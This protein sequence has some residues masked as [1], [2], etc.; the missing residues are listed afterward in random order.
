MQDSYVRGGGGGGGGGG[1]GG[2]EE[3]GGGGKRRIRT[4]CLNTFKFLLASCCQL[5][6]I[7]AGPPANSCQL[8][9]VWHCFNTTMK[10]VMRVFQIKR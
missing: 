2:A 6:E 8:A 1:D 10:L 3:E 9:T 5:A 4:R 7:P